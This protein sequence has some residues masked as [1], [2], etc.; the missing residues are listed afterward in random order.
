MSNE[1]KKTETVYM[2]VGIL[3]DGGVQIRLGG[4]SSTPASARVYPTR[5]QAERYWKDGERCNSS[6]WAYNQPPNMTIRIVEIDV[7][8]GK[9]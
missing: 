2:V 1:A 3:D 6:K 8:E 7:V 9:R 5:A 4:G